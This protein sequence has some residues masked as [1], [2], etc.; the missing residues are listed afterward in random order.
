MAGQPTS[1]VY[2]LE[3]A[4]LRALNA[5][6][7]AAF[8]AIVLC[9]LAT[10]AAA[11]IIA[12]ELDS[13]DIAQ[14]RH[15]LEGTLEQRGEQLGDLALEYSY[16]NEALEKILY[17]QDVAWAD[18]GVG[19]FL[20]SSRGVTHVLA[21]HRDG[22][23]TYSYS[24]RD[25]G[26]EV[27]WDSAR[28][29]LDRIADDVLG[30]NPDLPRHA[31]TYAMV[32][33]MPYLIVSAP[34]IAYEPTS[35]DTSGA[36][37]V[38]FLARRIDVETQSIWGE[39]L[40]LTGIEVSSPVASVE[41]ADEREPWIPVT[42][43]TGQVIAQLS[44]EPPR[45]GRNM[46]ASAVPW[47]VSVALV[48]LA[49]GGVLV[50]SVARLVRT[51][52]S[53]I[54]E[55]DQQKE[56]LYKQAMIDEVSNLHNRNYLISR[57]EEEI[58]RIRRTKTSSIFIFLDLDGFKMVND[59]MGH[60]AGDA[61]LR[62]VGERLVASV[63]SEDVIC[64]FG[65]DEFCILITGLQMHEEPDVHQVAEKISRQVI[66][67][68]DTPFTVGEQQLEIS[69]SAGIVIIPED[70]ANI[71]DILRFGDLAMYKAKL[72]TGSTFIYYDREF[73]HDVNYRNAVRHKLESAVGQKEFC[74]HYQPILEMD[75]HK[76]VG[77]EA[78]ARWDSEKLGVVRPGQFIPIAEESD[79][80]IRLGRWVIDEALR[81]LRDLR[82][83]V[84]GSCFI[85]I[86]VSEKQLED[87]RFCDYLD[88]RMDLYGVEPDQVYLELTESY[89][90]GYQMEN[91]NML[92]RIRARG[93]H[94][95]LD[96]FGTG[97]ASLSYLQQYPLSTVKIDHTFV[98]NMMDD[99]KMAGIIRAVIQ[100]ANSLGIRIVAEGVETEEQERALGE[101]GCH[102]VQGFHYARPAPLDV[103]RTART[104][105]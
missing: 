92:R 74:L 95:S 86:N 75:T 84:G 44:W 87:P 61:L 103:V 28:A 31:H 12:T 10:G 85:A 29:A 56:K 96:D 54:T 58:A 89:R 78:L 98:A 1:H 49:A 6:V 104:G 17:E 43:A 52:R 39:R 2:A 77:F 68:L 91:L 21:V 94:L 23:V 8:T 41:T 3:H 18:A 25:A 22:E 101:L 83:A 15:Q 4:Q 14:S 60:S 80:I 26:E 69:A 64:R 30:S 97:Y 7:L 37:G 33:G 9:L 38:L 19:D 16:W 65:G 20:N 57:M 42:D 27:P 11:W 82:E 63:R 71:E 48:F 62:Q 81:D 55:L 99:T 105:Q 50:T 35:R 72:E 73:L 79:T 76:V 53:N 40:G 59:T 24:A 88:E 36:H 47:G 34:F 46:L 102:W 13:R 5:R 100:M 93:V 67:E 90:F 66:A 51:A 70:S 45:H 32:E